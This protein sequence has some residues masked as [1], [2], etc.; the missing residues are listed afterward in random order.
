MFELILG[1]CQQDP[2]PAENGPDPQPCV[3]YIGTGTEHMYSIGTDMGLTIYSLYF[4]IYKY[5]LQ[6]SN[7]RIIVPKI[8]RVWQR[9]T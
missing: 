7:I 3:R 8:I 1:E 2:D 9:N 5:I 4:T 6:A